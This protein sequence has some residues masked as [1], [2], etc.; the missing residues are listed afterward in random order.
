MNNSRILVVEDE[1][2]IAELIKSSLEDK[3]YEVSSVVSTGEEA[4]YRAKQ[5]NIDLVLMDIVLNSEMTGTEA[6]KKIRQEHFVPIIFLTAY[7]NKHLLEHAK[8]SE[9][10]GYLIKPFNDRELYATIEMA[11]YKSKIEKKKLRLDSL[12]RCARKIDKIIAV[13]KNL[14][15]LIENI[16]KCFAESKV[17]NSAWVAI[18]NHP[19][20]II[21]SAEYNLGKD[22]S[23]ILNAIQT[24]SPVSWVQKISSHSN[25]KNNENENIF[26]DKIENKDFL[27]MKLTLEGKLF[28]VV[29]FS[30]INKNIDREEV[31]FLNNIA[32]DISLAVYNI[33]LE[34]KN[35]LTESNLI[36]SERR[37]RQVIENAI[38]IIFTNDLQGNF[39]YVNK[40]GLINTGYSSDEL[41][42]LNCMDLILPEH[43]E[44]LKVFYIKQFKSRQQS[45][46]IEY[47]FYTKKGEIKW[48][49][50]NTTLLIENDKIAGFHNI[51]RDITEQKQMEEALIE[52][53]KRYRQLVELSPDAVIVHTKGKIVFV[54]EAS[55]R[56]FGTF[57]RTDIID[58]SITYFLHPD[59][60][61]IVR[62]RKKHNLKNGANMLLQEQKFLK[63]DGTT[64]SVEVSASPIIFQNESS[65]QIIIRD[66]TERKHVE[67][68]LRKRQL[69]VN[70]LLDSLPGMAFFKDKNLRYLI[71]NQK[72]CD[73]MGYSKREII[74][75]TDFELLPRHIAEKYNADDLKV[76]N[77]GNAHY[78]R[79]EQ[80]QIHGKYFTIGTRKV[81]LKDENDQVIGLIGLGFDV[82]ERKEAE[83]AIK[84]YSK[85]LE[86]LNAEKDKFFSIISHDLRSP[87]Q[88]L[89]GISNI[90]KE[91]YDNLSHDEVKLFINNLYNSAKNL[92]N[93]IENLLQW[94][95]I[96]RGKLDLKPSTIELYEEVLYIINLLQQNAANKNIKLT[97]TISQNIFVE[98]DINVLTSTLQNLIS[99]AIKFT[100]N[101]GEIKISSEMLDEFIQVTVMD[102][103]VGISE[104]NLQKL[105]RVDSQVS[106]LGTEREAGTGLGLVICKE[107]I[108][109]QGGKIWVKSKLGEGS[110]FSFTLPVSKD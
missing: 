52:S 20:Q 21:E 79:E 94:S 23:P 50:Q 93:L 11:L 14:K 76:I 48:Y 38:D 37:Y 49:G 101:G 17:F 63:L 104:E 27:F 51:S 78:I 90:I 56:L 22:F 41:L 97:N 95:R 39:T 8:L 25:H 60:I 35:K 3:G 24:N 62:A 1:P 98:S 88:G 36:E 31:S 85:E 7:V 102:N 15:K 33:E 70:T 86:E 72:F 96:Q 4:I 40:A 103:G 59:S 32:T 46:Y 73:A 43:R 5:N 81:P 47:P 67:N 65:V 91:E 13:E 34:E 6:A 29:S 2:E 100:K 107:L 18:F 64:V 66:I 28:G 61:D 12:L 55:L 82:T 108:E 74:G 110:A 87:F 10:Y 54:N 77:S 105:F 9:P 19:A 68:E 44:R 71:V 80:I 106:T 89:L 57:K 75:K 42:K 26:F 30:I 53:E 84:K 109:R 92:F 99:N 16:S 69:E 45:T 83:E 58:K